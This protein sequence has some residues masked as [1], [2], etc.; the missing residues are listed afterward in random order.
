MGRKF[1]NFW[2]H[3]SSFHFGHT[4]VGPSHFPSISTMAKIGEGDDRWIVRERADGANVNAWHWSETNLLAW[5]KDKLSTELAF[6]VVKTS[7]SEIKTT[8][9]KITGEC[10]IQ[11]RKGRKFALY[12]LE[13]HLK[14]EG[15]MWDS[16][17]KTI[18]EAKGTAKYD[19]VSEET[20]DE[21]TVVVV[22]DPD[23]NDKLKCELKESMCKVGIEVLNK[24]LLK[25]IEGMKAN[26]KS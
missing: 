2:K 11:S 4:L 19:D 7:T 3:P 8:V 12:E 23:D 25:F 20:L 22:L 16:E 24:V 13:I 21:L 18:A 6:S 10:N 15:T 5:A 14:W 1:R 17:G 9:D 26:I